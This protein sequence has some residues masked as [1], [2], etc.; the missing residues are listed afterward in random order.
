LHAS[1]REAIAA[2]ELRPKVARLQAEILKAGEMIVRYHRRLSELIR[3]A[4]DGTQHELMQAAYKA[5]IE[6]K[7]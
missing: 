3:P 4:S 1:Q 5:E 6:R 7:N 2:K